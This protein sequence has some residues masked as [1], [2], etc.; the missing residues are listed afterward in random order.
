MDLDELQSV[1]SRERQTDTLQQLRPTFY[2]DAAEYIARLEGDRDRA[3]EQAD[4][5]W[6]SSKVGRLNDDI[7]TATQTVEAIYERRVGKIVKM[8]S[9]A[10]ADMPTDHDG[11][12]EEEQALFESLVGAIEGN[13]ESVFAILD[14]AS[15]PATD[16]DG[17][18]DPSDSEELSAA[19][20]LPPAESD[21]PVDAADAM[22]SNQP[23]D[24]AEFDDDPPD[25]TSGDTRSA[26]DGGTRSVADDSVDEKTAGTD[27]DAGQGSESTPGPDTVPVRTQSDGADDSTAAGRSVDRTT[28]RITDDVGEIFGVDERAYDLTAEDVVVL[29]KANASP[30]VD[31]GAAKRLD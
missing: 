26:P 30:L 11:L 24:D 5:P 4:D 20:G 19:Q 23:P 10:A 6:Q 14:G 22:G 13:R 16:S 21:V 2:Q 27:V 9:L 28:V 25:V 12:T 1:Q 8:A 15:A 18:A 29:P 7:D 3:A 31:R 17:R